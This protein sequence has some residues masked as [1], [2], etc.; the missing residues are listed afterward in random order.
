MIVAAAIEEN[1]D[2]IT[3]RQEQDQEPPQCGFCGMVH[4]CH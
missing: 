2:T 1:G 3:V 4:E